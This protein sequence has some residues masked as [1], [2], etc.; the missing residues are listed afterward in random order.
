MIIRH[1]IVRGHVWTLLDADLSRWTHK[2]TTLEHVGRQI[3]CFGTFRPVEIVNV[4]SIDQVARP[5]EVTLT[6]GRMEQLS[7]IT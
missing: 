5:T 4:G 2:W 1:S 6:V 3:Q 7:W